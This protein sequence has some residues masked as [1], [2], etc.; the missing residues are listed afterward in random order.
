M[1]KLEVYERNTSWT[2]LENENKNNLIIKKNNN[3]KLLITT[4]RS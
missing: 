2:S 3:L 4:T 1:K